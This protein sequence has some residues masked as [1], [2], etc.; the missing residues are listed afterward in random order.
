MT[1]QVGDELLFGVR[2]SCVVAAIMLPVGE[3]PEP[4][5]VVVAAYHRQRIFKV[6]LRNVYGQC[7]KRS[8]GQVMSSRI[9][10]ALIGMADFVASSENLQCI[11]EVAGFPDDMDELI[12]E[13]DLQSKESDSA[14][15]CSTACDNQPETDGGVRRQTQTLRKRKTPVRSNL[16]RQQASS[17]S[18][19]STLA[20]PIARAEVVQSAGVTKRRGRPS[21][22]AKAATDLSFSDEESISLRTTPGQ[23]HDFHL[24]NQRSVRLNQQLES[25][26][27][28]W[29]R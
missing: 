10:E 24:L 4:T 2:R 27:Q 18:V 17:T 5:N 3:H 12:E 13:P 26:I 9:E 16:R 8:S 1:I 7:E 29:Q 28:H 15:Q 25:M 21:K 19:S 11:L 14:A 20:R 6:F 23:M 22:K